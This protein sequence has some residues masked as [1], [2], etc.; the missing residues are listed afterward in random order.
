MLVMKRWCMVGWWC[1]RDGR[2]VRGI[3]ARMVRGR[4]GKMMGWSDVEM[5]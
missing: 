2:M 3:D 5:V 4:D 1:W